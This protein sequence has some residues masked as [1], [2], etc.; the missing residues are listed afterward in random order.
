[1][2]TEE[3]ASEEVRDAV[4]SVLASPVPFGR[5]R[6]RVTSGSLDH[7]EW[8]S[9]LEGQRYEC[10]PQG[11]GTETGKPGLP[12]AMHDDVVD[13]AVR[14]TVDGVEMTALADR[15]EDC[16]LDLRQL[17]R[18]RASRD[19]FVDGSRHVRWQ[20]HRPHDIA[21]GGE[22][23]GAVPL[24]GAE[25][26]NSDR[27]HLRTSDPRAQEDGDECDVAAG[28]QRTRAVP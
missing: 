21:F 9:A 19:P 8:C 27:G 5:P 15:D 3:R 14:E 22:G 17:T 20:F 16:V 4:E 10:C 12:Q 23:E 2:P 7:V 18:I 11:V 1:M 28:D 25:V 26:T 6:V 13:R 24:T